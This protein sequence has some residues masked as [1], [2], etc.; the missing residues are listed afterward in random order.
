LGR[1]PPFLPPLTISH[2][3][4]FTTGGAGIGTLNITGDNLLRLWLVGGAMN[5]TYGVFQS[6][7]V[8][9]VR[10]WGN[11]SVL[12][13]IPQTASLSWVGLFGP[14]RKI[15]STTMGVTP[16]HID[17]RPPKGSTAGFW[18]NQ[19]AV[20]IGNAV[21][22]LEV[23]PHMVVQ[24]DVDAVLTDLSNALPG[25]TGSTITPGV[26]YGQYLDGP[27]SAQLAPLELPLFA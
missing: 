1:I 12:G 15:T 2:S 8:K 20:N 24:V 23:I 4:R 9:R 16:L 7:K 25:D 18:L 26:F 10:M 6:I 17:S 11:P 22:T 13:G 3:F 14:D 27:S 19:G 21:M 5:V